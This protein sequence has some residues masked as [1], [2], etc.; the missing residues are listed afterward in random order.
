[1]VVF[2]ERLAAAEWLGIACIGAGLVIITITALRAHRD[3]STATA[4]PEGG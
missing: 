1:M 3:L 2:G 4:P